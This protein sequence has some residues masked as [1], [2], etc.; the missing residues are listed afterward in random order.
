MTDWFTDHHAGDQCGWFAGDGGL[1]DVV[2]QDGCEWG[3]AGLLKN[4]KSS[5]GDNHWY[6]GCRWVWLD[7]RQPYQATQEVGLIF[8]RV[9]PRSWPQDC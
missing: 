1:I 3:P 6:W 4:T 8:F 5:E 9:V 2:S 7:N